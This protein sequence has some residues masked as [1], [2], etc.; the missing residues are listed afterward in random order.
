MKLNEFSAIVISVL[1]IAGGIITIINFMSNRK[2][3]SDQQHE[4]IYKRA[5]EAGKKDSEILQS[6]EK[7]SGKVDD[8]VKNQITQTEFTV[9]S[10]K[11]KDLGERIEK[12]EG[13]KHN[14][15]RTDS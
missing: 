13:V 1:G 2:K 15:R 5:Y 3:D 4:N 7:L 12:L 11:V 10:S 14:D 9:L 6:I 8:L